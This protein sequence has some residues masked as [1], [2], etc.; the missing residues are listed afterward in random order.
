MD[1]FSMSSLISALDSELFNDGPTRYILDVPPAMEAHA[2]LHGAKKGGREQT[3]SPC[4]VCDGEMRLQKNSGNKSEYWSCFDARCNGTQSVRAEWF[5][6]GVVVPF[7]LED[8]VRKTPP[9]NVGEHTRA[10]KCPKCG[11]QTELRSNRKRGNEFWGC[12]NFPRCNGTIDA[13]QQLDIENLAASKINVARPK[14]NKAI[15]KSSQSGHKQIVKQSNADPGFL[16]IL[17]LATTKLGSVRAVENWMTVPKA[18]LQG[19]RPL[20]VIHMPD[21]QKIIRE[22]LETLSD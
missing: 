13:Q 8:F 9:A 1:K 3:P 14:V 2:E 20:D 10:P 18:A 16:R 6:D 21:A 11:A 7:E 17:E 19:K 5:Y 15:I 4:P 22:L 12:L